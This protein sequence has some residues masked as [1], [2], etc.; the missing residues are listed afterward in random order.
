MRMKDV[1]NSLGSYRNETTDIHAK[2]TFTELINRG[3]LTYPTQAFL[4]Q[5]KLMYEIFCLYCPNFTIKSGP[6]VVKNL[7]K[8][9]DVKFPR[10]HP[11]I[12]GFASRLF[13]YVRLATINRKAKLKKNGEQKNVQTLRGTKTTA[14]LSH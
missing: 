7:R 14:R 3:G 4:N 1:D 8:L 10:L 9:F 12:L 6:N 5:I 11:K 2:S 13:I